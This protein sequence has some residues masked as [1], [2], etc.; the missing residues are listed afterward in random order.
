VGGSLDRREVHAYLR[1]LAD[2]GFSDRILFA[3]GASEPD[4]L[5]RAIEAIESADFLAPP[6]KRAILHDNA[7]RWLGGATAPR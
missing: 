6:E 3:S 1:R 2:A 4:E 5:A 7:A